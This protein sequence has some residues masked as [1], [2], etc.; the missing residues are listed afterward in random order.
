M[1][2]A[3]L[4]QWLER[5]GTLHPNAIDLGLERVA[6]VARALDL[7]P[8]RRPVVTVAGTNGKGSTVAV[9]EEVVARAGLLGGA[10]TSPHLLRFNERIRV[11]GQEADDREII[12]AF[13]QVEGARGDIGLTYFEFAALA[14]LLVFRA[15]GVQV[16]IL[17]VGLGGRLDA[18][19]MVDPTVAVI[20]SIDLDHQD[21]LG[22]DRE[23]IARE[24]A[25]IMR[26]DRPVLIGEQAP[27]AALLDCA[28][29]VGARPV[30]RLGREFSVTATPGGWRGELTA[31]D[32]SRRRL[33]ELPRG[34]L[35]PANICLAL[36]AAL[37][38]DLELDDGLVISAVAAAP[39]AARCERRMVAGREYVMDVAH[40]PASVNNLVEYLDVTHCK[41]RNIAIFSVMKDKDIR[42]M[43][44][45]ASGH[46]SAWFVADQP[47][48]P[49]AAEGAGVA[50][51][52]RA[53][54][55]GPVSVCETLPVALAR[56]E[57]AAAT[58]DRLVIFG[59]FHTVAELAPLL[60]RE[61]A[62]QRSSG[63]GARP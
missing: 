38:L 18:V 11:G 61:A 58:D 32:G 9:L 34:A 22:G 25:G 59:S 62:P 27:P 17:E 40:N 13:E 39:P 6:T 14:A 3:S 31:R 51:L 43:I 20:T 8:V 45:A 63:A 19:N 49:R 26:R 53:Q 50:G 2:R 1:N 16:M 28:L 29:Q 24:K 15:R 56:A 36:Q 33:P 47:A 23:A 10:F 12:A 54:G 30:L 57:Q 5:L 35:L 21:W 37:L 44:E 55:Q 41:G 4:A 7:L 60:D 52:L 42:G 46:F 48:N